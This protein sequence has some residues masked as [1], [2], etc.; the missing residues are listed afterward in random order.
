MSSFVAVVGH[1]GCTNLESGTAVTVLLVGVGLLHSRQPRSMTEEM[2][3]WV[4]GRLVLAGSTWL[5]G[6]HVQ[7]TV[8]ACNDDRTGV[9]VTKCTGNVPY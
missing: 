2:R 3:H 9:H 5:S 1:A 7:P 4:S 8:A 6:L